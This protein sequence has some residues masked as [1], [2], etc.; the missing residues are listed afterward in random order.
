VLTYA[1]TAGTGNAWNLT[2]SN[3]STGE[4]DTWLALPG[5]SAGNIAIAIALIN[6]KNS[7]LL[8]ATLPVI[9]T[10]AAAPT[11]TATG[12]DGTIP[13][14]T[15]YV[16]VAYTTAAGGETQPSPEQTVTVSATNHLA[17][18]V[19]SLPTGTNGIKAYVSTKPGGEQFAASATATS[20]NVLTLPA[21]T[22]ALPLH[23]Q[24]APNM[25]TPRTA[26]TTA[27]TTATWVVNPI[28]A[29]FPA[30]SP[31]AGQGVGNDGAGA[32]TSRYTGWLG[33]PNIGAATLLSQRPHPDFV[34]YAE[35][36]GAD[37]AEWLAQAQNAQA[38]NWCAVVCCAQGTSPAAA[39]GI[40]SG[41]VATLGAYA[42]FIKVAWNWG[43]VYDPAGRGHPAAGQH[44]RQRQQH[45][46]EHPAGRWPLWLRQ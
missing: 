23:G 31:S 32:P 25:P 11:V 26:A 12:T 5:G 16:Q 45:D 8:Q 21:A 44:S 4:T 30:S 28:S 17:V 43:K 19:A 39:P 22:A 2:S 3:P 13:V 9:D 29:T 46:P 6:A 15:A 36:A 35:G 37:T 14:G 40:V 34:L 10:P 20:V 7:Y 41:Q 1:T 18:S 38:G 33:S 27:G 24:V 42:D